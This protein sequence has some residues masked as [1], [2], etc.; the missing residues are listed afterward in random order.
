MNRILI[1][2]VSHSGSTQEIATFLGDEFSARGELVDVRSIADVP[3]ISAYD[4]VVAGGLLYRFG[5]HPEIIRFL[6]KNQTE[7]EN[8]KVALFVTGLR[9]VETPACSQETFPVFIDPA[10][11]AAPANPEKRNLLDSYTTMEGYLK[12]VLPTIQHINPVQLA[13]FAGKLDMNTLN[14]PEKMIMWLL[15]LLTGIRAGDKR[16]WEAIR[17][18]SRSLDSFAG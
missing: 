5:W 13:F 11:Q 12:P 8:K 1:T 17:A 3:D 7:L 4:V 16:N 10:I 6:E 15:M 2:Y 14:L 18:W 9:L